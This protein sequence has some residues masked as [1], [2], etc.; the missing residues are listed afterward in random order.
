MPWQEN[1]STAA[2]RFQLPYFV[3][4][5]RDDIFTPTDPAEAYFD[6]ISA[7]KKKMVILEG[8]GHFA[9]ATHPQQFLAALRE[10][11]SAPQLR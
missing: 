7:P 11:L 5:G 8:A 10:V 9:L 1:L 2:L 6:K 4:Q 3:I